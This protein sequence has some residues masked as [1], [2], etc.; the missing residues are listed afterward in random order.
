LQLL[1]PLK[2]QLVWLKLGNTDIAN[3]GLLVV[4]QCVNLT[5]LH[6]DHTAVNDQGLE[7]LKGL[8]ALR[9]L[10]LVNTK[11]TA[12]GLMKLTSLKDL[13]SLYLYQTNISE[14]EQANLK[15]A[16]PKTQIDRGGYEVPTLVTDTTEVKYVAPKQ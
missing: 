11:I 8:N 2:K 1:L 4:G 12:Q 10:N 13:R 15:K 14:A 16:F 7:A 9:Y 3:S 6:L 5:R